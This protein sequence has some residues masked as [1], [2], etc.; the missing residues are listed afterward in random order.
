MDRA[1]SEAVGNTCLHFVYLNI[2]SLL[3]KIDEIRLLV[4]K[5]E[6]G[7]LFFTERGRIGIGM[8]GGICAFVR[9]D[10]AYNIRSDLSVDLE[11][12]WLDI[13]LPKT[14]PILLGVCSRPPKQNAFCEGL[15]IVL[16][17]CNDSLFFVR[18]FQY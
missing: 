2:R 16:S 9:L 8:V 1:F 13:C 17:N 7:V 5:S 6:V 15:E 12:V 14:K 3:P 4:R 11:I 10:I 18:G